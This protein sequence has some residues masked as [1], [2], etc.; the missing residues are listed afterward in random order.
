M[1][2]K[3]SLLLS[4]SRK[5]PSY[6]YYRSYNIHKLRELLR[7]VSFVGN[8][9]VEL[10][11]TCKEKLKKPFHLKISFHKMLKNRFE[12]SKFTL[13]YVLNNITGIPENGQVIINFADHNEMFKNVDLKPALTG[14]YYGFFVFDIRNY[15]EEFSFSKDF[16]RRC[17]FY[18]H[19]VDYVVGR[20]PFY[21]L[22]QP[23]YEFFYKKNH[24]TK[25]KIKFLEHIR[26]IK[27]LSEGCKMR[28]TTEQ[29]KILFGDTKYH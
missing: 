6:F 5:M 10:N 18:P 14:K 24:Y 7:G 2:D 17:N 20:N 1:T 27:N 25:T 11:F 13:N 23:K 16:K 26:N 28:L 3:Y 9:F 12:M 19:A 4:D 22:G 8:H 21:F 15:L 29:K